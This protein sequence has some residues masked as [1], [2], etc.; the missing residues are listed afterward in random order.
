VVSKDTLVTHI[1]LIRGIF[2]DDVE[3][4][5]LLCMIWFD[6]V[7]TLIKKFSLKY[8]ITL[9]IK[10]VTISINCLCLFYLFFDEKMSM[11]IFKTLIATF[12]VHLH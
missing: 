4:Q 5:I 6:E 2:R 1:V 12:D 9:E 10:L 11:F 8:F 3:S 7:A